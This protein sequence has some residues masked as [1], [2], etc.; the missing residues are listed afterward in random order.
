MA[1]F[2]AQLN[3]GSHINVRA[4]RMTKEENMLYAYNSGELVA[5]VE[6]T[7]VIA[8]YLSEKGDRQ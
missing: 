1:R 3:D 7:A 6:I 5:A 4:D 8:A 2:I